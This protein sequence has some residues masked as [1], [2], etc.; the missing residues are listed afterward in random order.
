M[1]Q[2]TE[3][4]ARSLEKKNAWK[5]ACS[6]WRILMAMDPIYETDYKVCQHISDAIELA[7]AYKKEVDKLG[8]IPNSKK[9][10]FKYIKWHKDLN[11]VFNKYFVERN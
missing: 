2:I 7:K 5:E 3:E 10:I 4:L 11:E 8:P 6:V 9:N 1:K